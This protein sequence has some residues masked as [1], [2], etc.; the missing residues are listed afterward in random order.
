MLS[1]Y[2]DT[3][4]EVLAELKPKLESIAIQNTVIVMVCNFGQS[5][6]LMNFVCSATKNNLDTRNIIV[7]TTDQ[8]TT[9]LVE[10]LGLT[11]FYDERVRSI[12]IYGVVKL[13]FCF[14]HVLM[15]ISLF[16]FILVF[17]IELW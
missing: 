17:I 14:R 11:A 12:I 9:D 13:D 5:E 7:F 1:R 2:F 4:D 3:V 6:L 10:A 16:S 8:E 15:I